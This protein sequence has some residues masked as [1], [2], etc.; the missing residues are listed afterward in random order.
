[1]NSV[2]LFEKAAIDIAADV[3]MAPGHELAKIEP[4]RRQKFVVISMTEE[5]E[6]GNKFELPDPDSP[7]PEAELVKAETRD[8][9]HSMLKDLDATD[10]AAIIMQYWYDF[11]EAEIAGS[12]R[13]TVSA[14]K[15]RLHR[16][17]K[18]LARLWQEEELL[19]T[20]E[21]RLYESP[22]F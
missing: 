16:A 4:L 13:L 1:M 2:D 6:E 9:I 11:S 14:V 22:A 19:S 3:L 12:L 18:E 7:D 15:N 10:R 20:T 8:Q 21:K 5:D 17:L